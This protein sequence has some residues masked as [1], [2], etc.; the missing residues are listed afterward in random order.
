MKKILAIMGSPKKDGN[1]AKMLN[2]AITAAKA[3][4]YDVDCFDLYQTDIA[5]CKGCMGCKKSRIC[6]I[7]DDIIKI[8]EK[9]LL[10]DLVVLVSPTYFANVTAPVK[11]LFD[12]LVGSVMDDNNSMI[13]K[14]L[15]RKEQ[16]YLI[17]TTCNTP[18]PFDRIARQ[19]TRTLKAMREFFHI[20]GMKCSGKI[21]FA[22]TR[23][24]NVPDKIL[25]KIKKKIE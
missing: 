19:S 24:K 20:S 4:G 6:I 25:T 18:F 8:R 16:K 14:P 21:I 22:G 10:C 11:N 3:K 2:A 7:N 15:L 13:P 1:C 9:L 12:R 23:N 5:Y 17:M